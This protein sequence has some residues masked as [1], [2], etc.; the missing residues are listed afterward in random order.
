MVGIIGEATQPSI[1][2]NV[3]SVTADGHPQI[4]P[5]VGGINPNV[6]VGDRATAFVADHIE[7]GVSIANP[8]NRQNDALNVFACVGNEAVIVTGDAKGETGVVTGKHGGIHHVLVDFTPDVMKRIIVG[9]KI[10]IWG[11]GVGLLLEGASDVAAFNCDP[12][13]LDAWGVR[14]TNGRVATPVT[15][16]IPATVM[17]SGLGASTVARGDYDIQMF[18]EEITQRCGLRD[19][20]LGDIVAVENADNTYGRI[21]KSGSITI[22]IVVHGASQVAGHGPGMTTLLTSTSGAIDPVIQADAN[23]ADILKLR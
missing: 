10:Q 1:S 14:V 3:Y 7:P 18:D 15:R 2:A 11:I 20:R 9:D 17:G 5:S 16:I 19:I 22:G 23:L 13:F 4:M 12:R 6:R 8:D 21:Y